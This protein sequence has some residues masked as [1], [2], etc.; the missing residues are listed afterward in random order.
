[1]EEA[2]IR[3]VSCLSIRLFPSGSRLFLSG[4]EIIFANKSFLISG[5]VIY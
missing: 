5:F 4:F 1:M 2:L 3:E